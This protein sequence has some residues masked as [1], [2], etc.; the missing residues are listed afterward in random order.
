MRHYVLD[1]DICIYWLN[2]NEHIRKKIEKAKPENLRITSVTLAELRYGAYNSQRIE[3][4]LKNIDNFLRK[5]R[6]LS[7]DQN[8][9][10]KFGEIKA[11]LRKKG[12]IICDFDILIA[13]IT[14]RYDGILV[15]NNTDH[16]KRINELRFENWV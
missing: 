10:D 8:A 4:N 11:N 14:L 9:A 3:E 7:L 1:T 5:A 12:E 15:T 16:F 6:V 13:S 2:G